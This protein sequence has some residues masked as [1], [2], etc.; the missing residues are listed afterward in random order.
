MEEKEVFT[1]YIHSKGLR[2]TPQ[3]DLVLNAF[4]KTESHVSVE[5]LYR[6]LN[7]GKQKKVGYATVHRTMKLMADCGLA[8]VVKFDDGVTRF[9]HL[10]KHQRHHHLVCTRCRKVIEFTSDV[11]DIE[12]KR[13]LA[14]YDFKIEY[15]SYR[16][17]GL[18]RDCQAAEKKL[19]RKHGHGGNARSTSRGEQH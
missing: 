18:C 9:E 11:I 7:K 10:Y 1:N 3:R 19:A 15:H 16:I 5:D 13:I 8:R 6:I 14:D 4:L 17:F 12:E 2:D